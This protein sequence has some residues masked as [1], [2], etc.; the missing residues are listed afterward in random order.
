MATIP[1]GA[2]GHKDMQVH[3][4]CISLPVIPLVGEPEHPINPTTTR[5]NQ[6]THRIGH[7]PIVRPTETVL[8][9]EQIADVLMDRGGQGSEVTHV[10]VVKH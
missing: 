3:Q 1:M 6:L 4:T 10:L 9:F 2:T 7:I 5:N 8:P